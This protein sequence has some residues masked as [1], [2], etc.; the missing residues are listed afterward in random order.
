M[1]D[2]MLLAEAIWQRPKYAI[3]WKS[4]FDPFTD[5]NDDYVVLEWMRDFGDA[6]IPKLERA[7][8]AVNDLWTR[9]ERDWSL[10]YQIGD[11][12]RA[13]STVLKRQ[14]PVGDGLTDDTEALQR[15]APDDPGHD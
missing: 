11:Y 3:D 8:K 14:G 4:D 15:T 9:E 6:D 1:S 12:A 13:A 2:R 5:A 10:G 7:E